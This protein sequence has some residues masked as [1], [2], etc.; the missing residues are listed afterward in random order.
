M[1]TFE[2]YPLRFKEIFK[3]TVWG[4]GRLR[5]L[6]GKDIPRQNKTGESWEIADHGDDCS[7]VA[8]GRLVERWNL[9]RLCEQ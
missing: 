7:V 8:N 9:R 5:E 4:G 2:A 6:F 1:S 3:Q